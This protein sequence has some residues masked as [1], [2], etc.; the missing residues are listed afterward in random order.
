MSFVER[1]EGDILISVWFFLLPLGVWF[2]LAAFK[3]S[4]ASSEGLPDKTSEGKPGDCLTFMNI[5]CV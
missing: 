3:T 4:V 2:V 5:G 1:I